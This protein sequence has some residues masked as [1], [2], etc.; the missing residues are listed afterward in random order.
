MT[1]AALLMSLSDVAAL[2]KVKRPV[3]SVW[4]RRAASS[5]APF[6]RPVAHERGQELFDAG[7]IAAWLTETQRGN[8][9]DAAADSA[10]HAAIDTSANAEAPT[11]PPVSALLALRIALGGP[12]AALSREDLLD[13]A[14]E[15]DPDDELFYREIEQVPTAALPALTNY[16]DALVEAAYNEPAAFEKLMFD[17]L[18]FNLRNTGDSALSHPAVQ[19]LSE[20]VQALAAT[21]TGDPVLVD[22]SGSTGDVVLAV[23]NAADRGTISSDITV[24]TPDD[25]AETSRLLRRRL[26]VHHIPQQKLPVSRDGTFVVT[27][28][29]VHIAQY[30]L[31]GKPGMVP[32]EMLSAIDNIALQMTD[33]QLAVILAPASVLTDAGVSKE[34]DELRSAILRSGRVRAMV[35]LPAG[36]VIHRV[37]QAQALWVLGPAHPGVEIADRWSLAADLSAVALN[38]ATIGDLVSDLIASLGDRSAVR[39]H[40]FRFARLALTR[41]L[42]ASRGSLVTGAGSASGASGQDAS[43]AVRA[44]G[45]IASLSLSTDAAEPLRLAI[46]PAVPSTSS[47]NGIT[48]GTT[49]TT[50]EQMIAARHLRYIPGNRVEPAD[51]V[52][53]AED[54]AGIRVIGSAEVFGE[55]E[56][57]RRRI[58]RLHF[59]AVY[60]AGR[61]TEPGDVVFCTAPY[62]A[63]MV[64]I[65]GTSVVAYPA[66]VLR[67]DGR[68]PN[69]LFSEVLAADIASKSSADRRWRRWRIRH[70][71][72][73]QRAML[74]EAL[75]TLRT[76][77]QIARERLDRLDRLT[78]LLLDGVT[79]G[80]FTI[81]ADPAVESHILQTPLASKGTL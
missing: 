56:L 46:E 51:V 28:E 67:I 17:Q 40:S 14:D 18:K 29:A 57:G 12:V 80:G 72:H 4:R 74:T 61:V 37:R 68:D 24:L 79:G 33:E 34:C 52:E 16:V 53:S 69:G 1:E 42:L 25:K 78:A 70:V 47:D 31:A 55:R 20:T 76:H 60:P 45:L 8:N 23:A 75:A 77:Q 58:D 48:V 10:A 71:P 59:A 63:S 15:H 22:V 26:F 7:E 43:A 73:F 44:E 30:P 32:A 9:P 3:V 54:A 38:E 21:L 41:T 50:I 66:R 13:A 19:M 6:P 35:R 2:A 36:L 27:G 39:S 62:P 81:T 11:L 65:E 49:T 64:D 5:T